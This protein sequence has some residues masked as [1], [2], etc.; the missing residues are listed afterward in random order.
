MSKSS[1]LNVFYNFLKL[2]KPQ[3]NKYWLLPQ[4]KI[5]NFFFPHCSSTTKCF[6]DNLSLTRM[7]H[8]GVTRWKRDWCWKKRVFPWIYF[9]QIHFQGSRSTHMSVLLFFVFRHQL[10]ILISAKVNIG[11]HLKIFMSVLKIFIKKHRIRK[12]EMENYSLL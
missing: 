6:I 1:F 12:K 4:K 3:P 9:F 2:I 5:F 11:T 8:F 7:T 10:S